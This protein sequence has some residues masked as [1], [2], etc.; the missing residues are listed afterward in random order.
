MSQELPY[1]KLFLKR[2]YCKIIIHNEDGRS[3]FKDIEPLSLVTTI[4]YTHVEE[5]LI[6]AF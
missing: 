1:I 6:F 3:H 5:K 2:M 4:P